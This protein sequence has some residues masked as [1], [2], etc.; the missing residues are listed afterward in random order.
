[1]EQPEPNDVVLL[2]LAPG[3]HPPSYLLVTTGARF[4][5]RTSAMRAAK[6]LAASNGADVWIQRG[7][8]FVRAW[9]FQPGVIVD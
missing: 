2:D 6:R 4:E 9:R 7:Q 1:M 5:D 8:E 3:E